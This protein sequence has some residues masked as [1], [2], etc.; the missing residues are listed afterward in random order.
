MQKNSEYRLKF[1]PFC[2]SQARVIQAWDGMY[3][4]ECRSCGI[5]TEHYL[6]QIAAVRRWNQRDAIYKASWI[7]CETCL[8]KN[9]NPCIVICRTWS[10]IENAWKSGTL[11]ILH[12]LPKEQRW[13]ING[14]AD[15]THWM[16]MPEFPE[17]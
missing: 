8:P 9:G 6:T 7:S 16:P 11:M 15:V 5:G 14:M 1:C 10:M 12:Y 17:E 4:A 2:G 3:R 13:N